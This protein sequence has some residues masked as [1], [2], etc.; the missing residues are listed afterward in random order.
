MRPPRSVDQ[1]FGPIVAGAVA[2]YAAALVAR[3]GCWGSKHR[4]RCVAVLLALLVS[5]GSH[6]AGAQSTPP[7]PASAAYGGPDAVTVLGRIADAVSNSVDTLS[8]SAGLTFMGQVIPA[9]FLIAL[10]TWSG[11]KMLATG[12]GMGE[13]I[14]EW[15]PILVSFGVVYFLLNKDAGSLIVSTMNSVSSAL[16]GPASLNDALTRG[17]DP[18]FKAIT[19]V[20]DL[21]QTATSFSDLFNT[22]STVMSFLYGLLA[23]LLALFF[24]LIATVVMMAHILMSQVS[25]AIVLALAPVMVPFLMFR[26]LGFLFDG[27]LKFLVTSCMMKIVAAF[28]LTM[29]ASIL[30]NV[31]AT[32]SS[33]VA[34][35]KS[36]GPLDKLSTDVLMYGMV[37]L[38]AL[39]AALLMAQV[40]SIAHGLV[41]GNGAHG[42]GGLAQMA[43]GTSGGAFNAGSGNFGNATRNSA[44]YF[45]GR[46]HGNTKD[47]EKDLRYRPPGA[48][49]AYNR[50][51]RSG[52]KTYARNNP[53]DT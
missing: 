2:A 48:A 45:R 7:G 11:L 20:V 25:V 43:R 24:L 53:P 52:Q 16:G 32:A 6:L 39:L 30:S 15:V 22:G 17:A 19:A 10:M 23:R 28:M 4:W 26:P 46:T 38:F 1:P 47:A 51:Y 3:F 21:P 14:G 36:A 8:K 31:T 29:V 49:A 42:F 34:E 5:V 35:M 12:R 50:G 13:L 27:W 9:F 37:V 40:P 44:A 41:S 33:I 18:L